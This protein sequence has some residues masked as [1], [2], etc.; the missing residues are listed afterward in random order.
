MLVQGEVSLVVLCLCSPVAAGE[1]FIVKIK[2]LTLKKINDS[3]LKTS[4][5]ILVKHK[6]T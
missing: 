4:N 1:F 3:I 2:L 5:K 6:R